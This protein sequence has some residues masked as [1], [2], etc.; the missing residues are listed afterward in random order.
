MAEEKSKSVSGRVTDAK[1]QSLVSGFSS[2]LFGASSIANLFDAFNNTFAFI[3]SFTDAALW[4]GGIFFVWVGLELYVW[5]YR[6]SWK[7]EGSEGRI[8]SIGTKPRLMVL[9]AVLFLWLPPG[10][11]SLKTPQE[12]LGLPHLKYE[13]TSNYPFK[14]LRLKDVKPPLSDNLH[15]HLTLRNVSKYPLQNIEVRTYFYCADDYNNFFR[16]YY[17]SNADY[18]LIGSSQSARLD[19]P[20]TIKVDLLDSLRLLFRTPEKLE[21]VILPEFQ[22]RS[23]PKVSYIC[24]EKKPSFA[25]TDNS[26]MLQ[27]EYVPA[28]P[29]NEGEHGYGFNGAML[30]IVIEYD[31]N[32]LRF[33]ELLF[34]GMYYKFMLTTPIP[35]KFN[36][37]ATGVAF[38]GFYK[39]DNT[40]WKSKAGDKFSMRG[41]AQEVI[42]TYED[43]KLKSTVSGPVQ[44]GEELWIRVRPDKEYTL[45]KGKF[46]PVPLYLEVLNNVKTPSPD[47]LKGRGVKTQWKT[48]GPPVKR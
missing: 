36:Q 15:A 7:M 21:A 38:S 41:S 34:G 39:A 3:E 14:Y 6:P 47:S 8:K 2:L 27:E 37:A 11:N 35:T 43:G 5:N 24:A 9:G 17:L 12:V 13:F 26:E 48:V 42:D 30:K 40:L 4:T 22:T 44:P 10:V 1:L 23:L 31:V 46:F 33:K 20:E 28:V 19:P 29:H 32:E 16:P 18:L 45:S 25:F